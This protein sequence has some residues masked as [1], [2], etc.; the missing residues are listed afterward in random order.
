[1]LKNF[2]QYR[3]KCLF[4]LVLMIVAG[5]GKLEPVVS[6]PTKRIITVSTA[7]EFV[8]AIGSN[9]TIAL[10]SG[11]YN[12]GYTE[13]KD[14][15]NLTIRGIGSKPAKILTSIDSIP[16]HFINVY[17]IK[18]DNLEI[19][20]N[21]T[22][23]PCTAPCLSIYKGSDISILNCVLFGCGES[24]LN[25]RKVIDILVEHTC[26]DYCYFSAI[27]F[28][29]VKNG[30]VKNSH[31][32]RCGASSLGSCDNVS[33]ENTIFDA[34][35]SGEVLSSYDCTNIQL[36]ECRIMNNRGDEGDS[37]SHVFMAIP[38]GTVQMT[39]GEVSGNHAAY[40]MNLEDAVSFHNVKFLYNVFFKGH[41]SNYT[42]R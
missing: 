12:I 38:S 40:L 26:I 17:G 15:K 30:V 41:H 22:G 6:D 36:L 34:D 16:L 32:S 35:Y 14:V 10:L 8:A 13:I 7:E 31:I 1:M 23:G 5:C 9:R 33:F 25:A 19:G 4:I 29:E 2:T 11:T 24:G 42:G 18:L 3:F 37:S 27:S 20:H 28:A 39:G 21:E